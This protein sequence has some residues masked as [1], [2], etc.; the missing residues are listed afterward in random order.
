M[1][2]STRRT[3][4]QAGAAMAVGAQANRILGANDRINVAVV[5]LGGRGT[6]HVDS[7]VKVETARLAALCDV[8]QAAVEK[9]QARV[10]RVTQETPKGY[11]DMRKL[12]EDKS[13]DAVSIA[14]PN[15]WHALGAIWAMQAG[16]DVYCEK[17]ASHN[18]FESMQ[19]I[20]AAR[21]YGRMCQ[22]G[23][24]WRTMEHCQKAIKMMNEGVIGKVY[25]AKGL[26]FKVRRSIGKKPD[27]PTPP[28]V[29]WSQF[30]GPRLCDPSTNSASA[31][32][33]I[34][35]GTPATA[36]SGI[37]ASTRPTS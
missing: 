26:C 15:H 7:Y 31:T 28:G 5:G 16:K 36:T 34:G 14:T 2:I 23:S 8:N 30:L 21:K 33:G 37:R 10:Q 13:I 6:N 35:S 12:F 18:L 3:F 19:M 17:P 22:I 11:D 32:T 4:I 1:Q 9:A 24:Q 20:A 27:A 29:D 25:L